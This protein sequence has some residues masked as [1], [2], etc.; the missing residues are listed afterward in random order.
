M[1]GIQFSN[2]NE[3]GGGLES[4]I[5]PDGRYIVLGRAAIKVWDTAQ[6][7]ENVWTNLPIHQWDLPARAQAVRFIDNVTL[8]IQTASGLL[9]LNVETGVFTP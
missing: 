5:S 3:T 1:Q 7:T 8:E 4:A 6:F 9:Y 2:D